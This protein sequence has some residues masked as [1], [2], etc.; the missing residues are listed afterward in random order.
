MLSKTL[1]NI[2]L[3]KK[4]AKTFLALLELG[5]SPIGKIAKKADLARS[6]TYEALEAL[7]K[8]NL[9]S[10]FKKKKVNYFTAEEPRRIVLE[11]KKKT[12]ELIEA[13]PEL[14]SLQLKSK[15]QPEVR[16]YQG[17]KGLKTVIEEMLEEK[18]EIL[19]ISST[20]DLFNVLEFYFPKFVQRRIKRK[21]PIRTIFRESE[22]ARERKAL[23]KE[24]LRKAKLMPK[25]YEFHGVIAIWKNKVAMVSLKE[26]VNALV[27]ASG[28]LYQMYKALFNY[29]WDSLP[30]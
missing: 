7:K 14:E 12:K 22:K 19:A 11:N 6:T 1:E 13:L 28:E 18:N 30:D 27:L 15:V 25:E 17:K 24:Q 10:T 20:D 9:V 3:T 21:I 16:F 2:G 8:R 29:I 23:G 4:Q 26:E 5:S